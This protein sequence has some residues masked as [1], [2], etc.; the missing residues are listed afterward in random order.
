[1]EYKENTLEDLDEQDKYDL[2]YINISMHEARD[3]D[4][5]T[6]NVRDALTPCG[7]FV[8]SDFTFPDGHDGLRTVPA[9]VITAFSTSR[10]KSMINWYRS[11]HS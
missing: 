2:V 7:Y 9:Q 6:K 5:A 3:I 8:N 1:M 10:H 11:K 4:L